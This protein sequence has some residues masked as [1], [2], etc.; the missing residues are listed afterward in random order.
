MHCNNVV[1]TQQVLV[2]KFLFLQSV[3]LDSILSSKYKQTLDG[4]DNDTNSGKGTNN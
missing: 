3:L 1:E 2:R 4:M